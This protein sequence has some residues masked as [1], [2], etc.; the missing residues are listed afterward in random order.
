[1]GCYVHGLFADPAQRS[2]LLA[3]LGA[4]GSGLS[5]DAIVED[6]L[7]AIA[8]HLETHINLDFLLTLAGG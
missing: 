3:R 7:D 5:Y 2:A 1:M 6:A 4:E 8:A